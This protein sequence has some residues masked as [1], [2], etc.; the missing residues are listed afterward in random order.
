[1]RHCAVTLTQ[2]HDQPGFLSES[3]G[4]SATLGDLGTALGNCPQQQNGRVNRSNC[5]PGCGASPDLAAYRRRLGD[6]ADNSASSRGPLCRS[7]ARGARRR[8]YQRGIPRWKMANFGAL[9][10]D[11]LAADPAGGPIAVGFEFPGVKSVTGS[12]TKR[13]T[14]LSFSGLRPSA[15]SALAFSV[16]ERRRGKS[17]WKRSRIGS[18]RARSA[19]RSVACRGAPK[20]DFSASRTSRIRNLFTCATRY[21]GIL[22]RSIRMRTGPHGFRI[23]IPL[24]TN[25]AS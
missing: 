21:R 14:Q 11:P 9:V 16:S 4:D 10:R 25:S 12:R 15:Y 23:S 3:Q 8:G 19:G 2:V 17:G 24:P 13:W 6:Y 18:K 20:V 7:T 22:L 1:M 5:H